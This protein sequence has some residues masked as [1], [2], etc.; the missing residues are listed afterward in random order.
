VARYRIDPARS[1]VSINARSSLHPIHTEADGLDGWLEMTLSEGDVDVGSFS[2]HI[3]F[4]VEKL[5]SGKALEDK[6]LRRRI[7]SRRFPTISGEIEGIK[8]TDT[9]GRYLVAGA[10]TFRGV[11]RRYEDEVAIA[12]GDA[13]S[14]SLSG[15]SVFDIRDFGMEPPRILMLKV[16]PQVTVR[17]DVVA[18]PEPNGKG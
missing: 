3:E 15:Q 2:G 5:T 1:R 18:T 12:V 16:E 4:P 14:V 9:P 8:Q 17:I 10:L 13:S 11:T 7:D 6:E